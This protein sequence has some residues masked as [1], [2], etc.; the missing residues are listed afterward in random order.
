MPYLGVSIVTLGE[1]SVVRRDNGVLLALLFGAVPLAD[2]G[3]AR[4][5]QH[6]G[7]R[8]LERRRETVASDGRAYLTRKAKQT[9]RERGGGGLGVVF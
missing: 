8:L 2:A 6:R 4:I 9:Q 7:A 1:V 5:G 3:A